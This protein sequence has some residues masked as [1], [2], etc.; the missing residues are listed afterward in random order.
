M[1][2]LARHCQLFQGAGKQIALCDRF[3]RFIPHVA[4][5]R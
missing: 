5:E 2:P 4:G 1:V 3:F